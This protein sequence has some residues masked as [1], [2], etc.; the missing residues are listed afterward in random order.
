MQ[1]LT[2]NASAG[3]SGSV[4]DVELSGHDLTALRGAAGELKTALLAYDGVFDIRD[5]FDAG[6]PELDIRVSPEGDALGLGQV[7]LAS[8]VRQA[9]FGAEIQRVQRGRNEVRVYVRF[10][11]GERASLESL[12]SMWI[13]IPGRGKVPFEVVGEARERIGVSVINRFNRQRVVNVEADVDKTRVEPGVVDAEIASRLLPGILARYP[14]VTGRLSGEAEDQEQTTD[15]LS[16]G[17]ITVLLMIY[18]ALAVPLRSYAQPLIIMSVI[19]FGIT[20]AILGHLIV[21]SAVSV[22]SVIGMIGLAGIVINDSL[23]LVDHIN[24]RLRAQPELWR[25]AV[26]EGGVRRFRPVLLTSVTTF[27]GL[28]PIQLEASIQAQFVKPMAISIAFGVMFAT[29]VTLFMVPVLYFVGRDIS[30]RLSGAGSV[31][32]R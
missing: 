27:M 13:D 25:E 14:G 26:I 24:E 7:E 29:F 1:S 23:V 10:P 16:L 18:A 22:L 19:P 15:A 21:G 9:F 20:G 30:S 12:R 11:A 2:L 28:L 5:S 3:P 6:G 31:P 8:Q 4:I 17:A 32:Q